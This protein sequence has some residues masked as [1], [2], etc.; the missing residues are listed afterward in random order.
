VPVHQPQ[1]DVMPKSTDQRNRRW[2]ALG[3]E[4]RQ[5]LRKSRQDRQDFGRK[6]SEH[7]HGGPEKVRPHQRWACS[8]PPGPWDP[9]LSAVEPFQ[10]PHD[11]K[12]L[13]RPLLL[14]LKGL[15]QS[16]EGILALA[17]PEEPLTL[18]LPHEGS[19]EEDQRK[20]DGQKD[21]DGPTEH[22]AALASAA[23]GASAESPQSTTHS[24]S[25]AR[26]GE[27]EPASTGGQREKLYPKED[28]RPH[29]HA[30]ETPPED[31]G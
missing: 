24:P 16:E 25:P 14:L 20:E 13:F 8:V 6:V 28:L 19:P 31:R 7:P 15:V 9:F 26:S 1:V 12:V 27:K 17:R 10:V 4:A 21:R 18:M 11:S 23:D 30:Q 2:S 5:N 3:A 29:K 22:P